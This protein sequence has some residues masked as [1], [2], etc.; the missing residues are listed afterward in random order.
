M[1]N[2]NFSVSF[3]NEKYVS[4]FF[5]PKDW[6]GG[7]TSGRVSV[8]QRTIPKVHMSYSN[9]DRRL[10]EAPAMPMLTG[11]EEEEDDEEWEEVDERQI[12]LRHKFFESWLWMDVDLPSKAERDG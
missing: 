1:Q 2:I 11:E 4:I 8:S 7:K 6:S 10:E 3:K 5:P 9:M 12:Y